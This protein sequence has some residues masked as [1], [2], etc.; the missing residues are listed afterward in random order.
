M[1]MRT[2]ETKR[3]LFSSHSEH[4][5]SITTKTTV[6]AILQFPSKKKL[7]GLLKFGKMHGKVLQ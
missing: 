4:C 2:H 5:K 7:W 6:E 1:V 3:K